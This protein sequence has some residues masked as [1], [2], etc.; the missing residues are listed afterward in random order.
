MF[1]IW[2]GVKMLQTIFAL[3]WQK[4]KLECCQ[5]FFKRLCPTRV[6]GCNHSIQR[7]GQLARDRDKLFSLFVPIMNDKRLYNMGRRNKI[8]K[9]FCVAMA[10]KL[11]SVLVRSFFSIILGVGCN[12]CMQIIAQPGEGKTL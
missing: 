12:P 4:N 11:I 10:E 6:F 7:I 3:L 8:T 1:I 5:N 2:I 9:L